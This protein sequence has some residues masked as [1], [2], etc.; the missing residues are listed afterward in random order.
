[1]GVIQLV[2]S[3][4]MAPS[5]SKLAIGALLLGLIAL[6]VDYARMLILRAKMVGLSSPQPQIP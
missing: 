1:M 3:E 2:Q 6:V 4:S 5:A